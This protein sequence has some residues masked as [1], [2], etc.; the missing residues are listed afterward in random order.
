MVLGMGIAAGVV[1]GALTNAVNGH[2]SPEYFAAV[3][4][5]NPADA[6][7][8]AI[9]QGVL[10]GAIL[11]GVFGLA[12]AISF[13]ASTGARGPMGLVVRALGMAVVI[14]LVCWAVFGA[15]G[16]LLAVADPR[17]FRSLFIGVP[18]DPDGTRRYAWVG[19]TIWGGYAGALMGAVVA[20]VWQHRT[21][22][23]LRAAPR[24]P[25][26]VLPAA[27]G[28]AVAGPDDIR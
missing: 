8:L 2:V 20:C 11:G 10:E 3:M 23:R 25:F 26:E 6:G 17:S 18:A 13:A 12:V 1:L 21:W 4:G 9:T 5:W 15:L 28:E 22:G 7:R 27:S 19:G 24:T 14:V 16:V